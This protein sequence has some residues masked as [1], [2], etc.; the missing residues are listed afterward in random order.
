MPGRRPLAILLFGLW[1]LFVWGGRLRNLWLDPGGFGSASRWSL[2]GSF[3]FSILAIAVVSLWLLGWFGQPRFAGPTSRFLRPV[4]L[5][6]AGL[7]T[8]VWVIRGVDIAIGDHEIAFIVVHVVLAV[9]SIGLAAVA[10]NRL[11]R[12]GASGA[13]V[14][15]SEPGRSSVG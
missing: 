9:V 6:L 12:F 10:V 11:S 8:V 7:T 5:A 4:V 1:T 3:A 2:I 14:S 13:A 15:A